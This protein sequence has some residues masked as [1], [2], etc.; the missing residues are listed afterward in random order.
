MTKGPTGPPE[1]L[2]IG[3]SMAL[4]VPAE[5][6]PPDEVRT[7]LRTVGGAESNVASHLPALGVPSAWVSAVGDD[8]FGRAIVRE[9]AAAGVDVGG[10]VVDPARPTGLY[11]K[12]S[13]ASGSPVRYY[14]RG[15]AASGMGPELV[16]GL[17]FPG[18]RVLHLSG[19]T[20]ALSD[21]C[22]ALV[23]ALLDI[24]RDELLVSFDVNHRPALW[25]GRDLSVLRELAGRADLVLTGDDEAERVW[26]TGDPVRLRELLPGPRTL[27]VKRGEHGATLVEDG[28]DP[29]FAPAL[30]VEVVEPVGAGDAFAAGFLAATLRGAD[31]LTR[32]RQGHLQAAAT[33]LTQDDVGV[34][35]P[36]E[37]VRM[38]LQADA[39]GWAAA[40]LTGEGVTAR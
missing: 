6:G 29:L 8:P 21:S 13:G 25:T 38:L 5:P 18:V 32:L 34:P 27:V 19:I 17:D 28:A 10:V 39:D 37:M 31:P 7:W 9:I 36:D 2:C 35:L 40:R 26:G 22:E 33:L 14:R 1:V 20:P 16:S 12:E 3:E 24:P 23:R 4:F 11:L 15:S 30:R